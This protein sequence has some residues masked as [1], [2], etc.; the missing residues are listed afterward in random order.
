MAFHGNSRDGIN[1]LKLTKIRKSTSNL[2]VQVSSVNVL[3][4]MRVTRAFLPLIRKSQGRIVNVSSILGRVA[5]PFLGA[6]CISKFALEAFSDVLRFE[7][8]PF[9]VKVNI[10]EP[11]N[12]LSA[13]NIIGGV[14]RLNAMTRLTWDQLAEPVRKDY[15]DESLERQLCIGEILLALSVP[16]FSTLLLL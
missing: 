9:N 10:I 16:F 1:A 8:V 2:V 14:E 11:G 5:D 3:G 13:V 12:F 4:V 6:Y 7:M 15:G